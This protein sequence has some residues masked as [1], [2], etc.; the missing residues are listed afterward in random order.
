MTPEEV[1]DRLE[2][3]EAQCASSP[4]CHG[5]W[6]NTIDESRPFDMSY[7]PRCIKCGA[8]ADHQL[9]PEDLVE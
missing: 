9:E 3:L 2:F 8:P 4:G 1:S 5:P 6:K 7:T